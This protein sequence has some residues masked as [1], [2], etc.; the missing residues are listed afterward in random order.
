[1]NSKKVR[2]TFLE[3]FAEKEHQIVKSAPMVI[4]NDPTLMFTNA[5]MNQFKD[6]FLGN[7]KAKYKR[8]ADTQKCL[9]VS[10]KHNDLEEV[11]HDTYHHTMFEMLGNWSFGNYFKKEAIDWCCELLIGRFGLDKDRMYATVFEGDSADGVAFDQEAY[12]LWKQYL[13]ESHILRGNKKDNFWEMGEVG[14]CGPCSE[15]HYDLR[16]DSERAKVDGRELVNKDNPLVIEIWNLVFMQYNRKNGGALELL[17]AKHVDTGMGFE[18][19]CMIMQGKKSNYDTDVFQE[20]IQTLAQL[21]GVEYG[22]DEKQSIAMRV[23]A[24]HLRAISFSIADGQMP[25]NVKAGYVIR[26]ILRRAVRYGYTYLNMREPFICRLVPTLVAQM[27]EQFDELVSQKELI[28]RVIEEEENSFLR[29]LATGIGLLDNI[30]AKSTDR[31]ISGTDAFVLY[32]T[33]GFPLDLTELICKENGIK[34][35]T[36]G[37]IEELE[38]QKCRSRNAAVVEKDDWI[39]LISGVETEFVGYDCQEADVRIARYRQVTSKNKTFFQLVFDV[40][41]FY[42]TQGGQLGDKGYIESPDEQIAIVETQKENGLTVHIVNELPE[43]ITATFHAVVDREARVRSSANHTATHLLQAALRQVLGNHVEQKGS[44]VSPDILRFDFS[45]FSAMT[46]EQVY[47]VERIVNAEIRANHSLVEN[48]CATIEEAKAGGAMMLF[49]EKYGDRVRTV[50]FGSSY[51][52]CGGIHA[53]ATGEIGLFKI[54]SEGAISAGVRRVEAVTGANAFE[55]I[56]TAQRMVKQLQSFFN[57]PAVI[58]A[59]EKMIRENGELSKQIDNFTKEKNVVLTNEIAKKLETGEYGFKWHVSH[60]HAPLDV[61]K[62]IAYMLTHEIED[63]IYINGAVLDDKPQLI[64]AVVEKVLAKGVNAGLIVKEAAKLMQG[65]GGGQPAMA[66][67]GGKSSE[68]LGEAI[69]KCV[70]LI[71]EKLAK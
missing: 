6:I 21:S 17:P 70:E 3:F 7:E 65:G 47:E 69:A 41:P 68:K 56:I 4:K 25:S 10:G 29:T 15:V 33:Y 34:V 2:A 59:V 57:T 20:V 14:P 61:Q 53:K 31:Q 1:M 48:R 27:G 11:G 45:H 50:Q 64:V 71:K 13:P 22:K 60:M 26:R 66:T 44:M 63:A 18:R 38:K 40:T 19:L 16:D 51:E 55:N 52:L 36:K 39:E 67:A 28:I 23:I 54:T 32:D 30:I 43:G 58:T 42:G 12:D 8:A 37:F 5:G 49:G 35:D 62:D 46:D 9:R 24:D